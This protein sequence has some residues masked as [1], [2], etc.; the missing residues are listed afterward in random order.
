M[1]MQHHKTDLAIVDVTAPQQRELNLEIAMINDAVVRMPYAAVG[2]GV[3]AVHTPV[4]RMP[5][6]AGR[7]NMKATKNVLPVG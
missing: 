5:Y 3:T 1:S 6:A 4:V 7:F 2:L